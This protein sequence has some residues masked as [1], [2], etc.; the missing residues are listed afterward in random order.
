NG[1][2]IEGGRR[3]NSSRESGGGVMARD[4]KAAVE[5]IIQ[6]VRRSGDKALIRLARKYDGVGL[7]PRTL[8]IPSHKFQEALQQLAPDVRRALE[9]C[10]RR[11]QE[12]HWIEKKHLPQSWTT[13]KNGLK[14]GQIYSPLQ[15]VG[16]YV[17]GG[18]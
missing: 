3:P 15:S 10:A 7:S 17:P 14:L 13:V 16:I 11:I 4:I 9:A 12:F 1:K 6:T 5:K 8:R 18:R 2:E